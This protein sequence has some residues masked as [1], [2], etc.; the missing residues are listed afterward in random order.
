V[1][2][3]LNK[4]ARLTKAVRR[5]M[6]MS[7]LSIGMQAPSGQLPK[8]NPHLQ[9]ASNFPNIFGIVRIGLVE[10]YTCTYCNPIVLLVTYIYERDVEALPHIT[11][12]SI[13]VSE[14]P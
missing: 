8:K 6:A 9:R 3:V 12:N 10:S 4:I 11:L 7:N 13:L 1:L 14:P 5:A 2:D